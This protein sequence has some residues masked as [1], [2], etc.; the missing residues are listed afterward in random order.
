[1]KDFSFDG[2]KDKITKFWTGQIGVF[3]NIG[4]IS[5]TFLIAFIAIGMASSAQGQS[6]KLQVDLG[7]LQMQYDSLSDASPR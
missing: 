7:D 2:T 3:V 1:M 4:C 5:F 6:N